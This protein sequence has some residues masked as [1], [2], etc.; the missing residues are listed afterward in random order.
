M[1]SLESE[2]SNAIAEHELHFAIIETGVGCD[3]TQS[4]ERIGN[5]CHVVNA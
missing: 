1:R 5:E 2:S 4:K 3:G